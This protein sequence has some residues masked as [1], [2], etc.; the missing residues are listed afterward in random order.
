MAFKVFG[1]LL[2][3]F[4][5][6]A[7]ALDF[8]SSHWIWYESA[9]TEPTD[10]TGEFRYILG[11][12]HPGG[13]PVS[14]E[15]I[16]TGDNNYTLSVNGHFVG[17]GNNWPVAQEY[18]VALNPEVNVFTAQVVNA[19]GGPP[20]PAALLAAIEVFYSDGTTKTIVTDRTWLAMKHGAGIWTHAHELGNANTPPWHTPTLPPPPAPLSLANSQW[21]WTKEPVS[22][23]G[24][25]KPIGSRAF[26]KDIALPGN[27]RATGGTI[28]ISTDNAYTLYINGQLIGSHADWTH[29]QTYSFHLTPP[30]HNI[31]VAINATNFGGPAGVIA[32]VELN[33]GC[34]NFVYV[35]DRTWKYNLH[36]HPHF[37]TGNDIGWPFAVQ[38]GLYGVAPW[39]AIPA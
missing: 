18:C 28:V 29:A 39:G 26:R 19:P 23:A 8:S 5:C 27:V 37:Q 17:Q 13:R 24:G 35:T 3:L 36:V 32:A 20:N 12:V 31:V 6:R 14:A 11:N 22:G 2:A 21:I 1:A 38:E 10:A 33:A 9:T 34:A 15:I 16:I 7:A 25:S 30:T 4:I